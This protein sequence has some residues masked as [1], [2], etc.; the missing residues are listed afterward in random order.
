[1]LF[2]FILKRFARKDNS[3]IDSFIICFDEKGLMSKRNSTLYYQEKQSK[4]DIDGELQTFT[5]L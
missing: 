4:L 5:H 1:M 3:H 2:L